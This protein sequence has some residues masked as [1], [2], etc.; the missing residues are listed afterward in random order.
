MGILTWLALGVVAGLIA[1]AIMPGRDPGG[2]IITVVIGVVGAML[3]GFLGTELLGWGGISG[4][5]FRS[6][7]LAIAGSLLLLIAYR[8]IKR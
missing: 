8:A 1:K 2:F 4:F 3:G 5:N 6:V 7:G